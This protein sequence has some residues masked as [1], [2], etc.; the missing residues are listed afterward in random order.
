LIIAESSKEQITKNIELE[1]PFLT[2]TF[3]RT[4]LEHLFE[5]LQPSGVV[6]DHKDAQSGGEPVAPRRREAF[7]ALHHQSKVKANKRSSRNLCFPEI[8][9]Y[10]N[11]QLGTRNKRTLSVENGK[12]SRGR[13]RERESEVGKNCGW[14][15]EF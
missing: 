7:A 2:I 3:I 10:M 14:P 11:E 5:D 15:G 4:F 1:L 12:L 9:T 8:Q 6:I 13:C